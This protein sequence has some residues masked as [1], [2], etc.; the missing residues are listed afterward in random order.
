VHSPTK[1]LHQYVCVCRCCMIIVYSG[2]P[3]PYC[4][5]GL[6]PLLLQAPS[7]SP[8]DVPARLLAA[9]SVEPDADEDDSISTAAPC[10]GILDALKLRMFQL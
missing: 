8:S 5:A 1:V 6:P 2:C 9:C 4:R 10:I 7:G 3:D